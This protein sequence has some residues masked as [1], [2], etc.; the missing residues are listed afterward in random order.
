MA[1]ADTDTR[2]LELLLLRSAVGAL[3]ADRSRCEDCGR[4]P[5]AGE[6]VH[7]YAGRRTTVVCELCRML[8]SEPPQ[9]SA[10]VRHSGHGQSV[11][12]SARAA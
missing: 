5:L 11:R 6:Y 1:G 8:R 10:L 2:D 3:E 7:V 4:T 12:I 9:Q